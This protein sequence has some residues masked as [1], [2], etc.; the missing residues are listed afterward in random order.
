[1]AKNFIGRHSVRGLSFVFRFVNLF[2]FFVLFE[3]VNNYQLTDTYMKSS[4]LPSCFA[5]ISGV[6]GLFL[7][8]CDIS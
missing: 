1:M 6:V 2:V 3:S 8:S 7:V 4:C 5:I